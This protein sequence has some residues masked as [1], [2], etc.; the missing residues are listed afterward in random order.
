MIMQDRELRIE[1]MPLPKQ[2][3]TLMRL[4]GNLDAHTYPSLETALSGLYSKGSYAIVVD[5]SD[6]DYMASAGVGVLIGALSRTRENRGD[7]LLMNLQPSVEGVLE[8]L[9]LRE[10]FNIVADRTAAL[11][12][13]AH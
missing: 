3:A 9:G 4:K 2:G 13:L 6:L 8:V 11:A 10:M 1:T 12:L 7:V 5:M